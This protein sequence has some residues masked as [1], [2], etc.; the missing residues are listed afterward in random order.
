[1]LLPRVCDEPARHHHRAVA[2][3]VERARRILGIAALRAREA[4]VKMRE[5]LTGYVM[6]I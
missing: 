2:E 5:Q 4:A 6:V 3:F 1:M